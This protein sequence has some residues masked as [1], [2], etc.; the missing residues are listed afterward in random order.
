M[1][2]CRILIESIQEDKRLGKK[3]K[4]FFP[5]S[6]RRKH[7]FKN[8]PI[9]RHLI[10]RSPPWRVK[11]GLP[12]WYDNYFLSNFS[13]IINEPLRSFTIAKYRVLH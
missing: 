8:G 11:R 3:W 7:K 5:L 6:L 2:I 1:N 12:V 13:L 4:V 9:T 10:M